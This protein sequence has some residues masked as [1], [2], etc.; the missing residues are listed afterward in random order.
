MGFLL[1]FTVV[2]SLHTHNSN[3]D[4]VRLTPKKIYSL[5]L[6]LGKNKQPDTKKPLLRGFLTSVKST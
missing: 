2:L 3:Q 4:S 1:I 6:T 5:S